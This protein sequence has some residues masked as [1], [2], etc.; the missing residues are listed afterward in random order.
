MS[1]VEGLTYTMALEVYLQSALVR[2]IL[3]TNRDRLSNYLI[4]RESQELF[5]LREANVED[6]NGRPMEVRSDEYLIYMQEVFLIAD[7][8]PQLRTDQSAYAHFYVKKEQS[9][10]LLNVGPYW[11]RGNIHLVPGAPLHDVLMAKTRFIPVSDAT[12]V[13]RPEVGP[14]TYLVN[15]TKIGC[16]TALNDGLVE[17]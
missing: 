13:G 11:V 17:L 12:I 2:G 3:T 15:R 10:A 6:L 8:S 7:L 14:R 5:S 9:T 4:L 16:M 1:T